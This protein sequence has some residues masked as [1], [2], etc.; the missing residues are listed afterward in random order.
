MRKHISRIYKLLKNKW[1][2]AF[3]ILLAVFVAYY[4]FKSSPALNIEYAPITIGN[5]IERVSITGKILPVD[6]A[7]LSFEKSGVVTTINFKVGDHVNK[8]DIIASLDSAG[9]R[10]ALEIARA[11]LAGIQR[12]LRPEEYAAYLSTL[13]SASTTLE[14]TVDGAVNAVRDG[15]VKAQSAIVEYVDL[16]FDNPQSVNPTINVSVDTYTKESVLNNHRMLVSDTLS[17]WKNDASN[18]NTQN[19]FQIIARCHDYL[20]DIKS[21]TNEVS[22]VINNLNP[23]SSGISQSL[24]NTKIVTMNIALSNLTQA[25]D[26]ISNADTALRSSKAAFDQANKQFSLQNA[27]SSH[28][29]IAAQQARVLQAQVILDNDNIVSPLAGIITRVDPKKGEFVVT[30]QSSFSVQSDAVFKIEAY[31]PEADIA[32]VVLNNDANVT[33]DAYGSNVIFAAKVTMVDPAETVLDGVPTYKV[34]LQFVSA[35][36]RIRSG[37]TANTDILTNEKDNVVMVSSRAVIDDKGKK[38]VRVVNIDG[39]TFRSVPVTIGLKGSD[40]TSEVIS[41]LKEGDN[42]VTFVK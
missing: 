7:D 11:D 1:F 18:V 6:K 2:I 36:S 41:G 32:K 42:A 33:L 20:T 21:F 3:I 38:S 10:A 40:G 28:E 37:M 31:V 9:D 29:S 13:N 4:F 22:F 35:D 17:R 14:N 26:A 30:G 15:Y 12:G 23:G 19:V 16:F 8:G 27:G 24:I 5:V 34:T 25:I 39:K